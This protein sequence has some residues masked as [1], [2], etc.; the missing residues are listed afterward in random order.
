MSTKYKQRTILNT[1]S[2]TR[3]SS[4]SRDTGVATAS[5]VGEAGASPSFLGV[6]PDR[7]PLRERKRRNDLRML[8]LRDFLLERCSPLSV[9]AR[10]LLVSALHSIPLSNEI[11]K[12]FPNLLCQIFLLKL[13][14]YARK[15]HFLE[16]IFFAKQKLITCAKL[17]VQDF[18]TG[19]NFSFNQCHRKSL[20]F[21]Q[22]S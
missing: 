3:L 7:D 19:K 5:C 4:T 16:S 20:V 18:A 6:A 11:S 13:T 10:K 1:L 9:S 14:F 15:I 17:C 21:S 12:I 22:E 8:S 2:S